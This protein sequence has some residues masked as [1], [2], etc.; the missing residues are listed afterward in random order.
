MQREAASDPQRSRSRLTRNLAISSGRQKWP[1]SL[2]RRGCRGQCCCEQDG[3]DSSQSGRF[4]RE[5]DD[6]TLQQRL[7]RVGSAGISVRLPI[8]SKAPTILTL[9]TSRHEKVRIR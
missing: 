4:V 2:P 8:H 9:V 7:R 1:T 3:P 5:T 6:T